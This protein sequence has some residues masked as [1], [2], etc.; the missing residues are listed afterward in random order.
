MKKKVFK[1]LAVVASVAFV[2]VAL[3][4]ANA[5]FGNPVSKALAK[6]TAQKHLAENYAGT[7]YY[8]EKVGYNFKFS[9]Y[10]LKAWK[11]QALH[12]QSLL[13]FM[14]LPV[15]LRQCGCSRH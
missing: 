13:I 5:F 10:F 11:K 1:I 6:S 9:D 15:P 7:D 14:P 2:C 3:V 12:K 8:I 4:F